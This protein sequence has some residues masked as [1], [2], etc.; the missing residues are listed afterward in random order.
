M[1]CI[2]QISMLKEQR[3]FS[4]DSII[5][6]KELLG[7]YLKAARWTLF[8]ICMIV[9]NKPMLI[10]T[11]VLSSQFQPAGKGS[12]TQMNILQ[13]GLAHISCTQTFCNG[14]LS[15]RCDH[16]GATYFIAARFL[17]RSFRCQFAAL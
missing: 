12:Y 17:H 13:K 15:F 5:M 11:Q 10:Y 4:R 1:L 6:A 8:Q 3:L 9:A 2:I 14:I 7:K 16:F